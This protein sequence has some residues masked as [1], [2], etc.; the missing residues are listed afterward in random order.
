MAQKPSIEQVFRGLQQVYGDEVARAFLAAIDDVRAAAD[1]QRF[2]T[3][4]ETRNIEAALDALHLDPAAYGALQ[5][6][7]QR[8]FTAGGEASVNGLPS[9]TDVAGARVVIRFDARNFRAE[10]WLRQHSSGLVTG[11][12]E[13]QRQAVREA[14]AVKME[15]G[16]APR[17]AALDI[18][19]RVSRVTGKRE[20]GLLGLTAS[21]AEWARKYDA[22][23]SGDVPSSEA[24]TRKL[25]DRRFD[26]TVAK[27]IREGTPIPAELRGKMVAAYRNR[28]LRLRGETIGRTEAMTSLHA[29]QHE[30]L[31]Q[32][33]E[34]GKLDEAAVRRVWKSAGDLRVRHTHMGLNNDTAGL[35]ERFTSPSGARL[36]YPG[37]PSAPASER[38]GCRCIVAVRIDRFSNL[39]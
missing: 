19:G 24:L 31:T 8:A 25:R 20:G 38:I 34:A 39:R 37:D 23:L 18:V 36:L 6:A 7:L 17:T 16:A 12:I 29:A 2:I 15:A 9:L 1:L 13:D 26:R 10:A 11:I 30:A 21:Q 32:A 3:A 27:A 5:D 35:N 4:V 33:V 14:L 28:A 22:E